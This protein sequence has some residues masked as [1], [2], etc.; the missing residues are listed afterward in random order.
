M[1]KKIDFK[2]IEVTGLDGQVH[3]FDMS[4]ELG[5]TIYAKTLDLGELELARE[6]YKNGEVEIDEAQAAIL[7]RYIRENFLAFVQEAICPVL[8][9]LF[10]NQK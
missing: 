5:N 10:N 8:E 4:K 9:N 2:V 1:R 7:I 6:I 3:H